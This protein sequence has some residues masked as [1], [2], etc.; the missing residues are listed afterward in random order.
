MN[1]DVN[2]IVRDTELRNET[3]AKYWQGPLKNCY[4]RVAFEEVLKQ[5]MYSR[6]MG[7]LDDYGDVYGDFDL[8][9][10]SV[11]DIGAGPWSMLLRSYNA[12]W[13]IAVDPIDWPPSVRRRYAA[14]K[15]EFLQKGGEDVGNLLVADEVWLYNCLQ[16]VTDPMLV[17]ENAK[18]ICKKIRIFEWLY[19]PTDICH[20]H[21]L[22]P[23]LLFKGLKGTVAEK[24]NIK[25][26]TEYQNNADAFIGIFCTELS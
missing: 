25:R 7:L 5:S 16:H 24:S 1:Y 12:K 13:R 26:M 9:G 21:F 23:E 11:I 2:D 20:P 3:E 15:I 22:T 8:S 14:Y 17:L 10:K 18:K 6:E 19:I 4:D